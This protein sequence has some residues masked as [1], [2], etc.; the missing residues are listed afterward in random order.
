MRMIG[1]TLCLFFFICWLL[2]SQPD[3]LDKQFSLRGSGHIV[4]Y[5]IHG[6]AVRGIRTFGKMSC[7]E[8]VLAYLY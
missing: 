7:T 4:A 1:S 6:A 3:S 8:A 2:S 5:P